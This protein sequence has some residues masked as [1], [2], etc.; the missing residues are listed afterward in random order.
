LNY[1]QATTGCRA[2]S[3]VEHTHLARR[4]NLPAK[5]A[6]R[7]PKEALNSILPSNAVGCDFF[8]EAP[9]LFL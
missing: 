6:W 8:V 2:I 9:S 7:L 5:Q 4:V 1:F 3:A